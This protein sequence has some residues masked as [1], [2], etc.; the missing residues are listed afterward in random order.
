MSMF[1]VTGSGHGAPANESKFIPRNYPQIISS[2]NYTKSD[3]IA[4]VCQKF[5]ARWEESSLTFLRF[6]SHTYSQ[7]LNAKILSTIINNY[8]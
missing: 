1:L 2:R 8:N 7:N 5:F 4:S 6:G 3:W